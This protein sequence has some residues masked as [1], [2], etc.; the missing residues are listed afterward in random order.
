MTDRFSGVDSVIVIIEE[1]YLWFIPV[2][3][4][5]FIL[6][7]EEDYCVELHRLFGI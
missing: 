4:V 5:W 6:F 2:L 7:E 3:L 1:M